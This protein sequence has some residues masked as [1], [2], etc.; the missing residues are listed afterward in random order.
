MV[1]G[2]GARNEE[3]GAGGVELRWAGQKD[4]GQC[5]VVHRAPSLII[6]WQH[7]KA[8]RAACIASA[9][10]RSRPHWLRNG[11]WPPPHPPRPPRPPRCP[12]SPSCSFLHRPHHRNNSCS[13]TCSSNSNANANLFPSTA[14]RAANL[15]GTQSIIRGYGNGQEI[16][17]VPIRS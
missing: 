4:V 16:K 8:R 14:H 11:R 6:D 1:G 15:R 10:Q 3:R 17:T 5:G 2:E 7:P 13:S 9:K 12:P